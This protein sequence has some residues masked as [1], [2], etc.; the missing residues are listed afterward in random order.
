MIKETSNKINLS[1]F[2]KN[3]KTLF[4][5]TLLA[6]TILSLSIASYFNNFLN[7]QKNIIFSGSGTI[8]GALI[9]S[10]SLT[11]LFHR[12]YNPKQEELYQS[13]TEE[14]LTEEEERAAVTAVL[15]APSA[16]NIS[17]ERK[18]QYLK[19]ITEELEKLL[20]EA[21]ENLKAIPKEDKEAYNKKSQE[22]KEIREALQEAYQNWRSAAN[23]LLRGCN[24]NENRAKIV[25]DLEATSKK[26][27]NLHN[28]Q[29]L[30]Q[31][32]EPHTLITK[33]LRYP[34][35]LKSDIVPLKN[36]LL[37]TEANCVQ[38]EK[39][40]K[41]ETCLLENFR[42]QQEAIFD[43]IK[44]YTDYY[45]ALVKLNDD[46]VNEYQNSD[47]K[48]FINRDLGIIALELKIILKETQKLHDKNESIKAL[49]AKIKAL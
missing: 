16:E 10:I 1:L 47:E 36:L 17:P 4:L 44:A 49:K 38:Q 46:L 15:Q 28:L 37:A 11:I 41:I 48:R 7:M 18:A 21:K 30:K 34:S 24:T 20:L 25:A 8:L 23:T 19:G 5:I 40:E 6:I 33:Q 39:H 32:T 42:T 9:T 35:A 13:L 2:F 27:Q 26:L 31:L 43:L 22:I 45:K 3:N 29:P 12:A 14:S